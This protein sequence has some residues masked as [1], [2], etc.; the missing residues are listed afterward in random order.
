M[1]ESAKPSIIVTTMQKFQK[2]KNC[3]PDIWT[4]HEIALI[5]DEAHRSHGKRTTRNLHG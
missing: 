3:R 2:L 5:A 4:R 1:V